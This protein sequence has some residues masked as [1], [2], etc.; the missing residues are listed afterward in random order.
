M[1]RGADEL[2]VALGHLFLQLA[3]NVVPEA[4]ARL[5]AGAAADAA[6]MGPIADVDD[7]TGDTVL[8]QLPGDRLQRGEG[9][10]WGLPLINNTFFIKST[11]SYLA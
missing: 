3:D 6:V 9:A 4:V 11:S 8:L 1:Y 10:L 7:L 5:A 2:A